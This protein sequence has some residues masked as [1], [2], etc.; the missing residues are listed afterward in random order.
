MQFAVS[1]QHLQARY[2]QERRELFAQS[3]ILRLRCLH[4]R[5][6][7]S[8]TMV[9]VAAINRQ[10]GFRESANRCFQLARL[11]Y[12]TLLNMLETMTL[13]Y[14]D[15]ELIRRRV[16]QLAEL[17]SSLEQGTAPQPIPAAPVV[18]TPAVVENPVEHMPAAPKLTLREN[19]VLAL[20]GEGLSTKQIAGKL[21]IT[22]KTA[23]C[24]REHIMGK[25]QAPNAAFL[26]RAAIKL[27]L[28]QA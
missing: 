1:T 14:S 3:E 18:P 24:H 11:S 20:I 4:S 7:S 27:G 28:I 6:E 12:R 16:D 15:D 23:A 21:G 2:H 25:L 8:F 10:L 5:I 19:E 17:L 22:F 26:V 13:P 9:S